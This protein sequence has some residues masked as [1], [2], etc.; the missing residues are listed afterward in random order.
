MKR[1]ISLIIILAMSFTLFSC[2]KEEITAEKILKTPENVKVADD[3]LISWNEVENATSYVVTINGSGVATVTENK[4]QTDGKSQFTCKITARAEGYKDSA[5]SKLVTFTPKSTGNITVGIEGDSEMKSGSTIRLKANVRGTIEKGVTWSVKEGNVTVSAD[6]VVTAEATSSD[7]TAVVVATSDADKTAY[8]EK[9]ITVRAVPELTQAMLDELNG[10]A[11]AEFMG[12]LGITVYTIA[13]HSDVYQT[14]T[15]EVYTSMKENWWHTKYVDNSGQMTNLYYANVD[16]TATQVG[17]NYMN[18]YDYY[19]LK[20]GGKVVSWEDSGLYNSFQNFKAEDFEFNEKTWKY[21]YKNIDSPLLSRIIASA[22]PYDFGEVKEFSL[23]IANG[24]VMG[25][26]AKSGYDYKLVNDY[27]TVYELSA[28][29]NFGD[30]VTV[31]ELP[32]YSWDEE[33]HSPLKEAIENMRSLTSFKTDYMETSAS[34]LVSGYTMQGYTETVT[35]DIC[36]FEPYTYAYSGND[37]VKTYD[38]KGTYGFKKINDGLYNTFIYDRQTDKYV[39]TRAYEEDFENAKVKFDFAPEI[40]RYYAHNSDGSTTYYVADEMSG[41][42]SLFY[43]GVG[44]DIQLYGLFATRGYTSSTDSFTPYVTVKDGYITDAC[45]YFNMTYMYGVIEVSFSDYNDATLPS[46]A[47]VEFTTRQVPTTWDEVDI[48]VS[49]NEDGMSTEDD[50]AVN[51]KTALEEFF[52]DDSVT[53]KVPFFGKAIG[54]TYGFGLTTTKIPGGSTRVV[55][56]VVFY[57]DVPLDDDYT[58]KTPIA[59]IEEYLESQGFKRN[60][61]GEYEKDGYSVAVV[62]SD[63]DLLVYLWKTLAPSNAE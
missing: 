23:F 12:T 55:R 33:I 10:H 56:A 11:T 3:G 51:A 34:L 45:F 40:F 9:M 35:E 24:E 1:I 25:F 17:L 39:A 29:I 41:V 31:P 5:P 19:P 37:V 57:F 22:N 63:L 32:K 49:G 6:G 28:V 14:Q 42:A 46:G 54:D 59:A 47:N 2:G 18:E 50:V 44:N 36:Y 53:D 52:D 15:A 38:E 16:G 21:E 30:T 27:R 62:D 20:D 61:Y 4:Y 8:A 13:Q 26:N 7:F 43:N 60:R 58:I 48:Y